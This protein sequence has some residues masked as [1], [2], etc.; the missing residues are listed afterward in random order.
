MAALLLSAL[1]RAKERA[2]TNSCRNLMRQIGLGLQM[3]VLDNHCYPPLAERGSSALCF[4]R[5]YPYYP[6]SWTNPVWNCPTCI[7]RSGLVSRESVLNNSEGISY[8]YNWKG[9][10]TGWSGSARSVS[11]LRLGLGHLSKDLRKEP[12][13]SAPSQMYSVADVR[14]VK[15]AGQGIAGG[16]KMCPWTFDNEVTPPHEQGYN[17]LFCDGHVALVK[18][19]NYLHP[20]RAASNWNS[21]NQPHREL[22]APV[23]LW[24]VQN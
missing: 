9:I 3:Y 20:P 7:A 10:A 19:S 1:S 13:V 6:L 12:E 16:I 18:R 11:E 2:Q 21:D 5:L 8:A 24:P 17:M 22:W 4:D 23:N 14:S 15:S